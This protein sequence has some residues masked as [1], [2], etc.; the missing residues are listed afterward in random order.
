MEFQSKTAI[1]GREIFRCYKDVD[2][3]RFPRKLKAFK[4][5]ENDNA[6]TKEDICNV[7]QMVLDDLL[8]TLVK[9]DQAN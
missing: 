5:R 8:D 4:N 1:E 9:Y 2:V 3:F 7:K 6:T